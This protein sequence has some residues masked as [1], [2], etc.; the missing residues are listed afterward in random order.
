MRAALARPAVVDARN[1]YDP[2]RMAALGFHYQSIGRAP[3]GPEAAAAGNGRLAA[4]APA[5]A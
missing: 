5:L 4:A 3:A 2:Q 1:L